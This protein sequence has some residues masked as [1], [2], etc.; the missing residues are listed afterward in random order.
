MLI[1]YICQEKMEEED[2]P[3]LTLA[4]LQ[5]YNDSKSTSKSSEEDWLQPPKTILK[6]RASAEQKQLENKNGKKNNRM[7]I[8]S[9]KRHLTRENL[10]V[11]KKRK[12]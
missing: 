2:L 9:D 8:L 6:T 7:D 10:D 4:L 12:P 5:Q 1:D 11:A 3:A